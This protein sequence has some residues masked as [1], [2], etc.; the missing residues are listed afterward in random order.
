MRNILES[1]YLCNKLNVMCV[2]SLDALIV[3]WK[4]DFAK[5]SAFGGFGVEEKS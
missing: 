5:M 4:Q 1:H 3:C 2:E